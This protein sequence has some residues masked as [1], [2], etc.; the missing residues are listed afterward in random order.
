VTNSGNYSGEDWYND[1]TYAQDAGIDAFALNVQYQ[2]PVNDDAVRLAFIAAEAYSFQL[3][4]SFDYNAFGPWD[5]DSVI[6]L[7]NTYS[8]S[9]AYFKYN[10]LPFVST[11]EGARLCRRLGYDQGADGGPLV[12]TRLVFRRCRRCFGSWERHRRWAFQ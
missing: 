4:F 2:D 6:N 10:G 9:P 1:I 12:C 8:Y 5:P 11:F 3:F 7:I